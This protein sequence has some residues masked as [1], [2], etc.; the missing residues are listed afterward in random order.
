MDALTKERVEQ[1]LD[2]SLVQ[3]S[4]RNLTRDFQGSSLGVRIVPARPGA[5]GLAPTT[6]GLCG[7]AE[8][9]V[10][11]HHPCHS[12]EWKLSSCGLGLLHWQAPCEGGSVP[13]PIPCWF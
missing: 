13:C 7:T 3:L 4:L 11:Q 1:V 5:K 8:L 10:V 9:L 12:A 2:P 6:L